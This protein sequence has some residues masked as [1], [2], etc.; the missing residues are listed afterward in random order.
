MAEASSAANCSDFLDEI[1]QSLFGA[2]LRL[3]NCLHMLEENS[4]NVP[5]ELDRLIEG[6]H[7]IIGEI[8]LHAHGP[9]LLDLPGHS[10]S[11]EGEG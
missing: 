5:G 3:E 6:L 11:S 8:R 1:A 9:A 2:G 10:D 4:G 7:A